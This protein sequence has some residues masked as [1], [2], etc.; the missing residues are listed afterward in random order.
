MSEVKKQQFRIE[1][2]LKR[3]SF[4]RNESFK[5]TRKFFEFTNQ[6]DFRRMSEVKEQRI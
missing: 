3:I 4:Y 5:S 2:R 1:S 6:N